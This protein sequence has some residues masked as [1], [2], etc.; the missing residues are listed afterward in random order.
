MSQMQFFLLDATSEKTPKPS[1]EM[2]LLQ[3]GLGRRTIKIPEASD[4][5]E[6]A[7]LLCAAYPKMRDLEGAWMLHKAMGGSGQ[8]RLTLVSPDDTGYTGAGLAR[9]W[10]GK[11]CLYIMPIQHRLSTAPLPFTASEFNDMPKARCVTCSQ[12]VPLRLLSLHVDTCSRSEPHSGHDDD[13]DMGTTVHLQET[14]E[15]LSSSDTPDVKTTCPICGQWVASDIVEIHASTCERECYEAECEDGDGSQAQKSECTLGFADI[16]ALIKTLNRR[17]DTSTTFSICVTREDIVE[18]GLKQWRRQKRSSPINPLMVTFIGE[19]GID[20]GA[21]KNEFLTEMVAGVER[22]FFEGGTTGKTPKYS[23][24]DVDS[25]NFKTIGEIFAVSIVQGGP[26]PNFFMPWCYNFIS[27]GE[28]DYET[29]TEGNVADPKLK[30]L[31]RTI[32]A[33]DGTSVL[34]CTERIVACGY[35]GPV[36]IQRKEQIVRAVVLHAT[37]RLLPILQQLCSGL[38]IYN[39]LS[40]VWAEKDMCRQLFVQH[41]CRKV[42]ADFLVRSLSPF[43]SEKGT[44][45]RQRESQIVNHLQDFIQDLEDKGADG[46]MEDRNLTEERLPED[47]GR[48]NLHIDVGKFCQWLTG[49]SHVPLSHADREDFKIVI[50]FDHDCKVRYGTH[51]TCYPVVNACSRSVTLPVVHLGTSTELRDVISK[52]IVYGYEFGRS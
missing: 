15:P 48:E 4:H 16:S 38:K 37:V 8:R 51:R 13:D 12:S 42:D 39:L 43:F 49:Q 29:V 2:V 27:T 6:I 3:A 44:V 5:H 35:T 28:L 50:E 26:P 34:E 7:D 19:A 45:K 18:R 41:P 11:G 36:S 46:K 14:I 32:R 1:E 40:M 23:I 20:N 17:V 33:A 25:R 31:I 52:A 21:L 30:E 9:A 10:G 22:C 47:P 24:T